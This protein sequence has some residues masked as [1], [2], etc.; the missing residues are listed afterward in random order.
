MKNERNPQERI[1][2]NI[3]KTFKEENYR[4]KRSPRWKSIVSRMKKQGILLDKGKPDVLLVAI[5]E[6]MSQVYIKD[7][8]ERYTRINDEHLVN[9][10][11]RIRDEN[12]LEEMIK[13]YIITNGCTGDTLNTVIRESSSAFYRVYIEL[14]DKIPVNITSRYGETMLFPALRAGDSELSKRL[15]I[16]G[17]DLYRLNIDGN[18]AIMDSIM[19]IDRLPRRHGT[20]EAI[21]AVLKTAGRELE[22]IELE[23]AERYLIRDE[24]E[25]LKYL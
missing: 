20:I 17:I 23:F 13:K 24:I 4:N 15:I 11:L 25:Y 22:G 3:L 5:R 2:G 21:R 8:I 1:I 6:N 16:N 9:A 18:T 10:A 12:I 14:E 19:K 7:L